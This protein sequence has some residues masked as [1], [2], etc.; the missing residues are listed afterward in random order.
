MEFMLNFYHQ[1][2]KSQA[3]LGHCKWPTVTSSGQGGRPEVAPVWPG[4]SKQ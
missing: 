2:E 3:Y 1:T 4:E